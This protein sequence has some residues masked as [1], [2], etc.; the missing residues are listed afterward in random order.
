M[1]GRRLSDQVKSKIRNLV[2]ANSIQ[3]SLPKIIEEE[4]KNGSI[5]IIT[6]EELKIYHTVKTLLINSIKKMDETRISYRDQK[7]S[8]NILVDDNNK[9]II[10]KITSS[11]NKY[12]IEI[13]NSKY[14]VTGIESIVALKKQLLEIT[15]QYFT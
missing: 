15:Q 4:S 3:N 1:D 10:A 6:A 9:K 13:N 8:F 14:D 11:R 7:N 12:F 2:N 5:V